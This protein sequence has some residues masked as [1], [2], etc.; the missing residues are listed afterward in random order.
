VSKISI[1]LRVIGRD[2]TDT[3]S[4]NV[5]SAPQS[6][7]TIV[8]N[9]DDGEGSSRISGGR[10]LSFPLV[11]LKHDEYLVSDFVLIIQ[12]L[13]IFFGVVLNC[14]TL[15]ESFLSFPIDDYFL[16]KDE[17]IS[18]S[19]LRWRIGS[20]SR[21]RDSQ[22]KCASLNEGV[23]IFAPIVVEDCGANLLF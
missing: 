10:N 16:T 8:E 20:V 23:D 19:Q 21:S 18:E 6:N 17:I 12:P 1:S 22:C 9:L 4:V 7:C 13:S 11:L 3:D 14:L 15:M 5:R 2:A